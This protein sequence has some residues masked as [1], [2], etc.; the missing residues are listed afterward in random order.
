[1]MIISVSIMTAYVIVVVPTNLGWIGE[2]A[3]YGLMAVISAFIPTI[4]FMFSVDDN[5]MIKL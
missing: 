2:T 1:M 4:F 5:G 3:A